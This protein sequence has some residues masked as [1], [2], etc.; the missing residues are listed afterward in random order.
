MKNTSK[1]V[2]RL[3]SFVMVLTMVLTMLPMTARA[4]NHTGGRVYF[5]TDWNT[6][7]VQLMI[8]HS[9]WSQGYHM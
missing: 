8:G 5:E 4:A 6:P 2:K 1:H 3:L 7:C 9:G